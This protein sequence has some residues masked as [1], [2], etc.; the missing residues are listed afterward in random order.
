MTGSIAGITVGPI[1]DTISRATV[2]AALWFSS[3]LFSDL[4]RRLCQ[5]ITEAIPAAKLWSPGFRPSAEANDGVGVY[6]DRV[7]FSVEMDQAPL[8]ES[9]EA[10]ISRAKSETADRFPTAYNR[11]GIKRFLD[12]YLQ[13]HYLILPD[14]GMAGGN[15]VQVLTPYLDAL[16]LMKSFP[17][18]SEMDPFV[19]L[20]ANDEARG[21]DEEARNAA[22]RSSALFPVRDRRYLLNSRGNIR[23]IGEIAANGGDRALKHTHYFAVVNAD[24]D[25]MGKFLSGLGNEDVERFSTACLEYARTAAGMAADFGGMPIYAGGDDLLFLSPVCGKLNGEDATVIDLCHEIGGLFSRTVREAFEGDDRELCFP[26]LSFGISVQHEKFPLYEALELGRTLLEK[27]KKSPF[28]DKNGG[29]LKHNIALNLRKHSGQSLG[30]IVHD[31]DHGAYRDLFRAAA[32]ISGKAINSVLYTTGSFAPLL[33]I[34]FSEARSKCTDTDEN[35]LR[36]RFLAAWG[37]LFDN[38]RQGLSREYA[39][40]IGSRFFGGFI[41]KEARILPLDDGEWPDTTDEAALALRTLQGVLS[42]AKFLREKV[43]EDE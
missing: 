6:H 36:E 8:R 25:S 26:T 12:A 17:A 39:E 34:L 18:S 23:S 22:I 27:A 21:Q 20:F 15:C 33:G 14:E 32:G 3:I 40:E 10:V 13:I 28:T 1:F 35:A 19:R 30:L 38:P 37:N 11:E 7:I 29:V 43:G 42:W 24:G 4:T 16:E 9:L 5:G 41:L 31:P 2:P